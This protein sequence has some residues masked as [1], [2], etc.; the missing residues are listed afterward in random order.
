LRHSISFVTFLWLLVSCAS[1]GTTSDPVDALTSA[2][3]SIVAIHD[4]QG[5]GSSSPLNGQIVTITG[6]VT[7]DFQDKGSDAVRRLGGFYLQEEN[8]DSDPQT[9][10]GIFV[11]D[12]DVSGGEVRT[13]DRVMVVGTVKEYFG[14]TQLIATQVD[15]TGGGTVSA[16][17]LTLPVSGVTI[18]T[19][20]QLIADLERFEG[21]LVSLPQDLTVTDLFDQERFGEISLSANGRLWQFTNSNPPDVA[22]YAS[23]QRSNARR[24][25]IVDDGSSLRGAL[26][27]RYVTAANNSQ[28]SPL[29]VGD[30]LSNL[31][32]VIRYA[33]GSGKSG[34]ENY[35]LEPVSAPIFE[36]VNARPQAPDIG[37]TTKVM[38]FNALNYF[39]TI[40]NG[41]RN[42]GPDG[43]SG[44]R[45]ADSEK[46]F[47]RQQSKLVNAILAAR[48]HIV[49]LMEIEN[50]VDESLRTLVDALNEA[51]QTSH[52]SFVDT[53]TV[54][55]DA[56]RVG[57]IYD[58][59]VVRPMAKFALLDAAIDPRFL[60]TKNR[61]ALAQTFITN[62]SGG[63][64]TIVVNHFKSK[65]SDCDAIGDPNRRD[66][67]GNCNLTRTRAAAA[68][69]AWMATDPTGSADPDI[70]IIG[71]MN[72]YL[73]E[74]PLQQIV[75]AGY[76]NLLQ[77]FVGTN[78]YSFI[79][80]GESG[81]L[82]HA[83]ASAALLPQVTGVSE[84]HI[85][86][87]ESPSLDYN[88]ESDRDDTLFDPDTPFRTSDHDPVMIGLSLHSN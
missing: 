47:E 12:R 80:R 79:Y 59:S 7:G 44:C 86:A 81:A 75:A 70:L 67:Q 27:L 58:D 16:T 83:F 9:S 57:I 39:T 41:Q 63:I 84:W 40:D 21:M 18:N 15:V 25:I 49:G 74:D 24:R 43:T 11:Y 50:N 29:R 53:G 55:T 52:W 36:S 37:G 76:R 62:A 23:H 42:C 8:P 28:E 88:L 6:I 45:G 56:I 54:G 66:G 78:A 3:R 87:D 34:I 60:D 38:S 22:A 1:G 33:R 69:A 14:E 51:S 73:R 5:N 13:G 48:V 65:G 85:N 72:A 68:L 19:D 4:I 20:G 35:R 32:G 71:D 82:D 64:F 30:K 17:R 46:E 26:P 61:K 10:E 31:I 2:G 77:E